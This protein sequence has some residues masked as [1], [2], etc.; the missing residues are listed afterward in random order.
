MG[1]RTISKTIARWCSWIGRWCSWIGRWG[2]SWKGLHAQVGWWLGHPLLWEEGRGSRWCN[3]S[4]VDN[5]VCPLLLLQ[6]S[7]WIRTKSH[8]QRVRTG[9][10]VLGLRTEENIWHRSM[11]NVSTVWEP[12][13][14]DIHGCERT[15]SEI[16]QHVRVFSSRVKLQG[17][18][19][20]AAGGEL[21]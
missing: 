21:Y 20:P 14:L 16:H 3:G 12:C 11:T 4:M 10:G 6:Y 9:K 5:C 2:C 15:E 13:L 7:Q 1:E 18:G 8:Q 17:S 19:R